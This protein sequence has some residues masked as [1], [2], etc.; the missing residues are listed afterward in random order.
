M[1]QR[2]KSLRDYNSND[3]VKYFAKKFNDSQG[4]VYPIIF[5]RDSAIMLK[6]MRKF[7]EA[8][9]PLKDIFKFIDDMFEEYPRRK[10]LTPIDMNWLFSMTGIYLNVKIKDT[11][12]NKVKAPEME[13][14]DE[15]KA[16]LES[17]K[18]KLQKPKQD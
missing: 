18:E 5:A 10:R 14:D 7:F 12:S 13:L 17:E 1:V 3:F 4:K 9:R 8:G 16:W 2:E 15:M 11:K 6:V